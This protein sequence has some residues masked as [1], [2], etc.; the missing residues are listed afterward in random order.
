MHFRV[1]TNIIQLLRTKY[2]PAQKKGINTIVGTVKLI[3]PELSSELQQKLTPAEVEEFHL[4]LNT[5][6][7]TDRLREELAALTLIDTLANA[8]RWF[9]REGTSHSARMLAIDIVAQWQSLR[10]Q[11]SKSGLLD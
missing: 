1:R 6:H 5:K 8:E 10:R 11:I 9:D 2:D 7:R 4:W 3:D